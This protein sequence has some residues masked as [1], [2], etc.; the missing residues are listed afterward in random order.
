MLSIFFTAPCS[1]LLQRTLG[2]SKTTHWKGRDGLGS[3]PDFQSSSLLRS[4]FISTT[5]LSLS[6]LCLFGFSIT[7]K[8]FE[9]WPHAVISHRFVFLCSALIDAST[10][11]APS[12]VDEVEGGVDFK[13]LSSFRCPWSEARAVQGGLGSQA[14]CPLPGGRANHVPR[15]QHL[16]PPP[17]LPPHLQLPRHQRTVSTGNQVDARLVCVGVTTAQFVLA[18]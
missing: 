17:P 5:C 12:S 18:F 7:S 8:A 6:L 13:T 9:A 3:G 1:F 15:N 2:E 4:F 10:S 16:H 14:L 11:E